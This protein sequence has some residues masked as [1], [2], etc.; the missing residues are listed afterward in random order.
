VRRICTFVALAALSSLSA[1]A[2]QNAI[3]V[4]SSWDPL[5]R[6]PAQA[7]FAWDD[8]ATSL[9]DDPAVDR[10]STD[11][12]VKTVA[13]EAFA[14]RGYRPVA[15]GSADY[16]MSYQYAVHSYVGSEGSRADGT[17]SLLLADGASG[18]RVWLGFGRAEVHVGL[19][20][21]ERKARLREALD[22]M[23]ADFPPAQRPPE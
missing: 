10:T 3:P 8:A 13:N 23:L 12:L 2:S 22:R 4:S 1:C 17:L 14:A 16:R 9:P 11:A 7:T 5:W 6:F 19:T 18:R 20:P 21:E 15:P